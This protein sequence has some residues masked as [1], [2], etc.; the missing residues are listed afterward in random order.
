MSSLKKVSQYIDRR[1]FCQLVYVIVLFVAL[2]RDSFKRNDILMVCT[3]V[4][5][6][7]QVES[8][9]GSDREGCEEGSEQCYC[10]V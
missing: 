10:A 6:R 1:G 5:V 3:V 4:V 9:D 2:T 8:L 7:K